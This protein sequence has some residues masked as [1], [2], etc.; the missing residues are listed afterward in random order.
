M[1]RGG[2]AFVAD[3]QHGVQRAVAGGAA[4]AKVTEKNSGELRQLLAGGAQSSHAFR[5]FGRKNSKLRC[6]DSIEVR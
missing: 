1:Q 3:F 5:G 4:R 2:V 6:A